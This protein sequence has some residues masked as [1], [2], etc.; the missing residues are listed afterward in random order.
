[1]AK[2]G[3]GIETHVDESMPFLR[4]LNDLSALTRYKCLTVAQCALLVPAARASKGQ[5][6]ATELVTHYLQLAFVDIAHGELSPK[7]PETLLPYLEYLR[8][9]EAGIYGANGDDMPVVNAGW[10]VSLDDAKKWL[11][12]KGIRIDVA[13]LEAD[14]LAL[15]TPN[16][17][18]PALDTVTP[19][20]VVASDDVTTGND[21]PLPLTTGNIAFSFDGLRWNAQQWKKPL[22][23]KP[24]W[25][26]ACIAIPGVRG[27][28]E[29][30]WN[31]VLIGAALV[32]QGHAK[33]NNVRAKFQTGH[34]LKP[35]LDA[36]K[37]YE[38]D[39]LGS[40]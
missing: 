16:K 28:S 40:N 33:P 13:H 18:A 4:T 35:W 6:I 27:T 25:L 24:K 29:T 22:G 11:L 26:K 32:Q 20:P 12:S 15:K 38:S 7:H 31:P 1:M 9:M 39:Y 21:V 34:L 5:A 19:A 30:R 36:W 10:L 23:D 17:T 8:M 37:T 14:L 2:L 3:D